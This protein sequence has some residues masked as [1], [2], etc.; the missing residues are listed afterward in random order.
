MSVHTCTSCGTSFALTQPEIG[1][2]MSRGESLPELCLICRGR[3]AAL[4]KQLANMGLSGL[5][6]GINRQVAPVKESNE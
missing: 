4:K 6:K 3:E 5:P 2:Y 1:T